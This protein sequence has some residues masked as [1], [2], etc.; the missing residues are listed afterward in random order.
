MLTA[1]EIVADLKTLAVASGIVPHHELE[2]L[3][4]KPPA[5]PSTVFL[6]DVSD[7]LQHGF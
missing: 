2:S 5:P 7:F 6:A 3:R 1:P 4:L